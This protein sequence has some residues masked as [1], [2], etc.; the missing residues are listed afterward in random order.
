MD[1]R[2][3]YIAGAATIIAGVSV[4]YIGFAPLP[5]VGD[6]STATPFVW[7]AIL[8]I[9]MWRKTRVKKMISR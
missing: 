8:G 3:R 1:W 6:V 2:I 4:A 9:F 5:I 7:L